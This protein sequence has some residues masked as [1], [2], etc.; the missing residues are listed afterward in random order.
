MTRPD[1]FLS[2]DIRG[3]VR[4]EVTQCISGCIVQGSGEQR[5]FHVLQPGA[6]CFGADLKACMGFAQAQPPS[7]LRLFFVSSQE[8]NKESGELFGS[9]PQALAGEK[10]AKDRV[11]GDARVKRGGQRPAALFT[12]ECFQHCTS[13]A[14]EGGLYPPSRCFSRGGSQTFES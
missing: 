12:T 11:L 13:S 1:V 4:E 9:T 14:H 6:P 10:R 7:V 8:L 5:R 2:D 3:A